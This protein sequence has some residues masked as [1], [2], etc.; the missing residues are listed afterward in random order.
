ME[1][2]FSVNLIKGKRIGWPRGENAEYI[3][4]LGNAR[5]SISVYSTPL[6]R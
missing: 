4:T 5:R 1:V 3:F 2:E 6:P